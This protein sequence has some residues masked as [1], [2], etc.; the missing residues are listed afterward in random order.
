MA[1]QLQ[2]L[3]LSAAGAQLSSRRV[4][5]PLR[6][7]FVLPSLDGGGAERV[8]VDLLRSLDRDRIRPSL[9]LFQQRGA[10]LSEVP[11]DL[12]IPNSD[13]THGRATSPNLLRNLIAAA[14]TADVIVACLQCRTTYLAWLAGL[15]TRKP[16]IGWVQ[17]AAV[18]GSPMSRLP[19]RT[20][21]GLVQPRLAAS[22]FPCERA[23]RVLAERISFA[24]TRVEIIPNFI[25]HE[26]VMRLAADDA[27]SNHRRTPGETVLIA[28]GR[29]APQ[30]GFDVLLRAVHEL[31]ARGHRCRLIILGEGPEH[32]S[33]LRLA[34]DLLLQGFVE[35]PG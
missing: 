29:L 15:I 23:Y 22:V 25:C 6:A 17:N 1:G 13:R 33:L 16:V 11:H 5:P 18:P 20:L 27:A 14:R 31:H 3:A 26:R 19:H 4:A 10:L 8:T 12:L 32:Q 2:A 9:F 24:H 28:V 21:M 30:K 34:A 7:L 35:M